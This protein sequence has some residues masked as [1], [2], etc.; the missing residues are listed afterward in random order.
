[1]QLDKYNVLKTDWILECIEKKTYIDW[2]PEHFHAMAPE[3]AEKISE[4]YDQYGDSYDKPIR[5]DRLKELM[6]SADV[7]IF[8][9]LW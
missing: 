1:M 3:T 9:L 7:G 6:K 4:Q 5:L 2:S 8:V